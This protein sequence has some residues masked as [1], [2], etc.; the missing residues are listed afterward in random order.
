MQEKFIQITTAV[1]KL[2][3]FFP[4]ND[5]LKNKAK[6]KVLEISEG[7]VITS[8]TRGWASF[9]KDKAQEKLIEDIDILLNYLKLAK[10]FGWI[11]SMNYIIISKEYERVVGQLKPTIQTPKKLET[12]IPIPQREEP[13]K[14]Q[15]TQKKEPVATNFEMSDR[16]KKI[17]EVIK[18]K[19]KAQVSDFKAVLSDVTKRTIRRDLDELLRLERV[20]RV[21]EWNKIEYQ[22]TSKTS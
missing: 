9:N 4:D 17:L 20:I 7:L 21:G 2:L 8:G 1:Y 10:H 16:Q 15:P 13:V 6:E 14:V 19:G 11:D 5:P 18:E 12:I 22:I 3:E